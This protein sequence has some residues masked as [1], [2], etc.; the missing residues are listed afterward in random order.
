MKMGKGIYPG[1]GNVET[2]F[3]EHEQWKIKGYSPCGWIKA[4]G[5]P[6]SLEKFKTAFATDI[7]VA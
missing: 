6:G 1:R 5:I 2:V 7:V 4:R 3:P